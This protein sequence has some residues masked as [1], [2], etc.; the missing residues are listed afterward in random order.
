MGIGKKKWVFVDG[1]LPPHGTIE[2]LGHEALI[3]TNSG[4]KE[5]DIQLEILF[6]DREPVDHII[7][8]VPAKRVRCIRLDYEIGDDEKYQIPFGQYS[9]VLHSSEP[10]VAVFGRL[11]RR[12][13]CAYYA[14]DGFAE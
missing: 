3:I 4:D 10:I 14:L 1:D 5:A 8:R 12:K 6:E 9:L 7:I 2:Q 11:D 13:D